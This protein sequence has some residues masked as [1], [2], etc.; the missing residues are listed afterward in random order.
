MTKHLFGL[1]VVLSLLSVLF[2][3]GAANA[4][5]EEN[6]TAICTGSG[7]N[8]AAVSDG[9]GGSVIVWEDARNGSSNI[10]IYAQ[11]VDKYGNALWQTNGVAIGTDNGNDRNP[12]IVSYGSDFVVVWQTVGGNIGVQ[13]I[14]SA[15]APVWQSRNLIVSDNVM[16]KPQIVVPLAGDPDNM[17][18]V[19]WLELGNHD[20][21]RAQ[22]IDANGYS[23]WPDAAFL[24]PSAYAQGE[25][26]AV[27][28]PLWLSDQSGGVLVVFEHSIGGYYQTVAQ[29]IASDSVGTMVFGANGVVVFGTGN[30]FD[31]LVPDVVIGED[32]DFYATATATSTSGGGRAIRVGGYSTLTGA[33]YW[34][35]YAADSAVAW[36]YGQFG[37][38]VAL[39]PEPIV[40]WVEGWNRSGVYAQKLGALGARQWGNG[41]RIDPAGLMP[42]PAYDCKIVSAAYDTYDDRAIISWAI[43]TM[44]Y[45]P[46]IRAQLLVTADTGMVKW[47]TNGYHVAYS[48]DQAPLSDATLIGDEAG[49]A[50]LS[51]A[52]NVT[53]FYGMCAS[54]VIPEIACTVAK[55]YLSGGS[56]T[57]Y[58]G[59]SG[60]PQGDANQLRVS[61]QFTDPVRD[62]VAA[63]IVLD[64]PPYAE[65][66]VYFWNVGDI[67]AGGPAN[68]G[69]SYATTI[70]HSNVSGGNVCYSCYG[71]IDIPVRVQGV[72]VG[73]V[74][75][76][77]ANSPDLWVTLPNT[78][79]N[80]ADLV[81]FGGSYNKS[82]PDPAFNKNCDY[83]WN[84][85]CNLVDY[86][87]FAA[88]YSGH[89]NPTGST[90]LAGVK[91]VP[92]SD[93]KVRFVAKPNMGG[94]GTKIHV[95]LLLENAA[96]VEAMAIGL[97]HVNP[98]LE[99]VGF[100]QSASAGG[101]LIAA[102]TDNPRQEI[103]IAGFDMGK[104][105]GASIEGGTLVFALKGEGTFKASD[106]P[107]KMEFC[108]VMDTRGGIATTSGS[109]IASDAATPP[110]LKTALGSNYP[111]P[112]NP[113][114]TIE[115]SIANDLQ[116]NLSIYNVNGQLVRT[117]VNKLQKSNAYSVVWNGK[118]NGGN[119]VGSGIYFSR[120]VAGDFKQ[121][122][123]LILLR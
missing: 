1:V 11:R 72:I 14:S 85:A 78:V 101:V 102:E 63:D 105:S 20:L 53:G 87:F 86:V 64:K 51:Y 119:S 39:A 82:Y 50:Y 75:D 111:N 32:E 7:S 9:A 79:V 62:V 17:A 54:R 81:I 74:T 90:P 57:G 29:R 115:Y 38:H 8:S 67:I 110:A 37:S 18:I 108:D 34:R 15:G 95:S 42:Y 36:T 27:P 99:F 69:N 33:S 35:T 83:N 97:S 70:T 16:T 40:T 80:L 52:R 22:A 66:G 71:P 106:A 61:L 117:L 96:G 116:V 88:H 55:T 2:A 23:L 58:E 76:F 94:K 25:F 73:K 5:W 107:F 104:N 92:K 112:F 48:G 56:P 77:K 44:P 91:A 118:D 45:D 84:N 123:K 60:C 109:E 100:E 68:S 26:K 4:K 89:A 3:A 103:L 41:K 121:S 6:G 19:I 120:M 13:R 10:D 93:V 49:G 12:A 43:Y 113:M 65:C 31:H 47:G 122:K 98:A 21:L 46:E 59:L 114:T 24:A 28:V 30:D